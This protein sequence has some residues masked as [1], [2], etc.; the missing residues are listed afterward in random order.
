MLPTALRRLPG[1]AVDERF[2]R[3]E[4]AMQHVTAMREFL[5]LTN[6]GLHLISKLTPLDRLRQLLLEA[7]GTVTANVKAF[8][9]R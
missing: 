4:L 2:R 8:F 3:N 9:D 5:C 6:T 7:N 1:A